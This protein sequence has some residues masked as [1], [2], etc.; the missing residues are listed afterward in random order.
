M[1]NIR[2]ATTTNHYQSLSS[3]TTLPVPATYHTS[4]PASPDSLQRLGSGDDLDIF[5]IAVYRSSI[6]KQM[7]FI[8]KVYLIT[9]LQLVG[10]AGLA[11]ILVRVD[12]VFQWLQHSKYAWWVPLIPT[13]CI[14]TLIA[15]HLWMR[16]FQLA[17]APRVSLLTCYSILMAMIVSDIGKLQV[18]IIVLSKL[19]YIDGVVVLF[20]SI[21]GLAGILLFTLQ[22][23]V[24][25]SGTKPVLVSAVSICMSSPWLRR[26]YD[27]DPVTILWPMLL[28]LIICGY[29]I[30]EMYFIMGNV[31]V[32]DFILA[33]VCFYIDALYPMRCLHNICELTDNVGVFPDIL[34]PGYE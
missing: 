34:R 23:Q 6:P 28:A 17:L 20:M 8:R 21:F 10:M 15:W 25:F 18:Y 2:I 3:S 13:F 22:T 24:T 30:L 29:T 27:M 31:T 19:C 7:R 9:T 32:D 33:N 26:A 16:Y 11:T 1:T 4:F 12:P 14:A 5:G